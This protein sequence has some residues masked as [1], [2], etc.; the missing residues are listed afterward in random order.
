MS[1]L[2]FA[3]FIEGSSNFSFEPEQPPQILRF[4]D[5]DQ[6]LAAPRGA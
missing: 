2:F 5:L 4:A 6:E 3:R 1:N